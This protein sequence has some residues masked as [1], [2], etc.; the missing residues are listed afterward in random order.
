MSH[1]HKAEV[2]TFAK[3][4]WGAKAEAHFPLP[5]LMREFLPALMNLLPAQLLPG[6]VPTQKEA[7]RIVE[8]E[9]G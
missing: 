1:L 7:E 2:H 3:T 5:L 8:C 6:R 9:R 4:K